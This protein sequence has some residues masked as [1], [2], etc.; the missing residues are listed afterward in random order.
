MVFSPVDPDFAPD[1]GSLHEFRIILEHGLNSDQGFLFATKHKWAHTDRANVKM[2]AAL[3]EAL[4]ILTLSAKVGIGCHS[5]KLDGLIC[6]MLV[7][8]TVVHIRRAYRKSVKQGTA[9]PRW[10]GR[11]LRLVH[12]SILHL[13][14]AGDIAFFD[15]LRRVLAGD[16]MWGSAAV[17]ILLSVAGDADYIGKA[18]VQRPNFAPGIPARVSEHIRALINLD[19]FEARKG[20]YKQLRCFSLRSLRYLPAIFTST[21]HGAF[22]VEGLAISAENP[23]GNKRDNTQLKATKNQ[24]DRLKWKGNRSRPPLWLRHGRKRAAQAFGSLW[25]QPIIHQC[26][27]KRHPSVAQEK[28]PGVFGA[29]L[30]FSTFYKTLQRWL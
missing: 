7:A 15:L 6:N 17:Y 25:V 1:D 19:H 21:E 14:L 23:G 27:L 9:A 26:L 16:L 30:G 22:I 11:I 5:K 18:N 8:T 10:L 20:R 13:I 4:V 28:Y 2:W 29:Q 3:T 24:G 12:P